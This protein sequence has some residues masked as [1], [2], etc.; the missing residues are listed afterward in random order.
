MRDMVWNVYIENF[1]RSKIESYNIFKHYGFL[2]DVKKAYKKY[3]NNFKA[4]SDE[5]KRAL[6]YFFWS[7]CEWEIILSDWPH[8]DSFHDEKVDVYDQ[9]MLNWDIFIKYVWDMCHARKSTKKSDS[10][11]KLGT[12]DAV[13]DDKALRDVLLWMEKEQASYAKSC[14]AMPGPKYK[15]GD[16]VRFKFFEDKEPLEGMVAIVDA[17]GTFEQ[18]EEPSYDIYKF[19]NN[20]LYKHIRESLVTEFVR[21]GQLSEMDENVERFA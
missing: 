1:N 5:V 2:T 18:N 11:T 8:H 9:V 14:K 17:Y 19:D 7:K 15:K 4:F 20:T 13:S 21:E 16:V 3:K 10:E 6:M 12:D